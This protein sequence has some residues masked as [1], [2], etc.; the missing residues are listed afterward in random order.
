ML[1]LRVPVALLPGA[2]I[3]SIVAAGVTGYLA[4][5]D[6]TAYFHQGGPF[7]WLSSGVTNLREFIGRLN[8]IRWSPSHFSFSWASCCK[9][10]KLQK[11]FGC[12]GQLIRSYRVVLGFCRIR[13]ASRQQQGLLE[14]LLSRWVHLLPAMLRNNYSKPLATDA[15]AASGLAKYSTVD[16]VDHSRRPLPQLIRQGLREKLFTKRRPA[17]C[18]C[19]VVLT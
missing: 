11:T 2:A 14:R 6:S 17:S 19:P 3:L 5:G 9:N 4:V 1:G 15:I 12:Y 10:Q 7:Q 18:R 13:G 16:C 8:E